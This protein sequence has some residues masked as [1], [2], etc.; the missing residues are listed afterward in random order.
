[1]EVVENGLVEI[2][3][4][5]PVG[6]LPPVVR[7]RLRILQAEVDGATKVAQAAV[8]AHTALRDAYQQAFVAA[9]EDYGIDVPQGPHDVD[10]DWMTGRVR[11][12]PK[13]G[14]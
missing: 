1:M 13:V 5:E 14:P 10:V 12:I 2:L 9:C 11:F 3:K 6:Q 4:E 8:N 7:R